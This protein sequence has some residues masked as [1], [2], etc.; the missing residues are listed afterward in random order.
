MRA[1]RCLRLRGALLGVGVLLVAACAN[2]Q[3]GDPI[4][5]SGNMQEL[6]FDAT[7]VVRVTIMLPFDTLVY[8]GEPG[9]LRVRGEDNLI[10]Y[11]DVDEVGSGEW[12]ISTPERMRCEQ[13][14]KVE[15]EIPY[16]DMV[17]FRVDAEHVAFA[18]DPVAVWKGGD[19]R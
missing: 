4:V 3:P 16:I 1:I 14:Q 10:S 11:I 6:T 7:S 8:N 2:E 13:H 12:R 17:D 5:G 15:V 9:K 19:A 18:D